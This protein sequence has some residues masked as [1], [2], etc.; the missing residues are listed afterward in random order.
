MENGIMSIVS[1]HALAAASQSFWMFG[2]EPVVIGGVSIPCVLSED[3]SS[4]SFGDVGFEE[5]RSLAA[6]CRTSDLPPASI[7]KKLATAR[8]NTYRVEGL[9]IGGTFT[10]F[11]LESKNKA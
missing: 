8:G 9:S 10:R 5:I 4:K 2:A 1:D 3:A 11:N 7:D 6:V